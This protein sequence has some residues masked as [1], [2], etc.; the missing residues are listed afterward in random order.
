MVLN[1][2]WFCPL[3]ST[4]SL[5]HWLKNVEA[6]IS[7]SG[8]TVSLRCFFS[9]LKE[10]LAKPRDLFLTVTMRHTGAVCAQL[11][12][13][14]QLTATLWT[15]AHQAPPSMGFFRQEYWSALPFPSPGDGKYYCHL[16]YRARDIANHLTVHKIITHDEEF[17]SLKMPIVPR[18]RNPTLE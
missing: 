18:L 2:E 16:V 17:S 10:H 15:I 13:R 3:P 9:S 8:S 1:H 11:L 12:S 7:W 14:V 5:I 4:H 6:F